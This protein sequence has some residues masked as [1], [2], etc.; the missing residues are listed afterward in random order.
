MSEDSADSAYSCQKATPS[1]KA[2]LRQRKMGHRI[3]WRAS[4]II[5]CRKLVRTDFSPSLKAH[6]FPEGDITETLDR[7]LTFH[8]NFKRVCHF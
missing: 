1:V 6:N 4:I 3:R 2:S 8:D 5:L 7:V